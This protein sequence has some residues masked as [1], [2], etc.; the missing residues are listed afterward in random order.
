V[1]DWGWELLY[2]CRHQNWAIEAGW[3]PNYYTGL[4]FLA[5]SLMDCYKNDHKAKVIDEDAYPSHSSDEANMK[6]H[7]NGIL[8]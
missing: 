6:V 2:G 5:W 3:V 4:D 7:I 8:L 1:L